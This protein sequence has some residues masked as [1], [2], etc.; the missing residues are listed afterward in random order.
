MSVSRR[1]RKAPSKTL[2]NSE[3]YTPFP[4]HSSMSFYFV[5]AAS[6]LLQPGYCLK[7]FIG[8]RK[9]DFVHSVKFFKLDWRGV[10][11]EVQDGWQMIQ[12]E[13][14]GRK[15]FRE[16]LMTLST[17]AYSLWSE[18]V[19]SFFGA[20]VLTWTLAW[21]QVGGRIL[22]ETWELRHGIEVDMREVWRRGD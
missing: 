14:G 12:L 9:N 8:A 10:G 15:L 13:V 16:T 21:R 22:A 2:N 3:L 20:L 7:P 4:E 19:V 6:W 17:F 5:L 1:I 18:S 11:R